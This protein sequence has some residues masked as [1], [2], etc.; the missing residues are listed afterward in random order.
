MALLLAAAQPTPPVPPAHATMPEKPPAAAHLTA[1]LRCAAA[2]RSASDDDPSLALLRLSTRRLLRA[3]RHLMQGATDD[4]G[5]GGAPSRRAL[6]RALSRELGAPLALLPKRRLP[7]AAHL[8]AS[9]VAR[10]AA[11][12]GIDALL[13][14]ELR[15][16]SLDDGSL[17]ADSRTA[18]GPEGAPPDSA[19]K[20]KAK[21]GQGARLEK[22]QHEAVQL[23][24]AAMWG[25]R[26]PQAEA[27]LDAAVNRWRE[28]DTAAEKRGAE[29][30]RAAALKLAA[31]LD[32]AGA[33]SGADGGGADGGSVG[34]GGGLGGR[35]VVRD[36]FVE[37][38]GVRCVRRSALAPELVPRV[39]FYDVPSHVEVRLPTPTCTPHAHPLPLRT[40]T[41]W[42]CQVLG[43]MLSD[44]ALGHHLLL[45]G[46]QGVGK[47]KLADKLLQ[48]L[49]A[50][51]EYVQLHRD[52]TVASLTLRPVLKGGAM[53][54][55][56]TPLVR[57]ARLGR[58]LM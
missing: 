46:N 16:A 28:D 18:G 38:G 33:R 52:T 51:R 8:V 47:N 30:T 21:G 14:A 6:R 57:A 55:E 40:P 41:P 29:Q 19:A 10:Q 2:L 53:A 50:E 42:A 39:L 1:L 31:A 17:L 13:R 12:V 7:R 26:Q 44:W 43:A 34:L 20:A 5:G 37:A 58:V 4:G 54:W 49:N 9:A 11:R 56:D 22:M 45:L 48:L 36:G 15:A 35:V 23:R 3:T 24:T 27:A 32:E 25:Q